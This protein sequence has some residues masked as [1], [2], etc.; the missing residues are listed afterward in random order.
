MAM[1]SNNKLRLLQKMQIQALAAKLE[2]AEAEE[3]LDEVCKEVGS[4]CYLKDF[5]SVSFWGQISSDNIV[6]NW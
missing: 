5:K 3:S 4:G 2:N 6:N 1:Q